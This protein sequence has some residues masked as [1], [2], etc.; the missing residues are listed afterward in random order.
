MSNA[1]IIIGSTGGQINFSK[2]TSPDTPPVGYVS[3]YSQNV[4]GTDTILG[5]DSDGNVINFGGSGTNGTSGS[6][7]SSG[8]SGSSGSSGVSGT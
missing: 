3:M 4:G 8:V 2:V 7:G 1:K 5:I 6:S